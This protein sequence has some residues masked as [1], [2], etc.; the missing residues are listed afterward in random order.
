MLR[1]FRS[2]NRKDISRS[3]SLRPELLNGKVAVKLSFP[4]KDTLSE[5]TDYEIFLRC[6]NRYKSQTIKVGPLSEFDGTRTY[7]FDEFTTHHDPDI[8]LRLVN[9]Q[10]KRIVAD[11]EEHG[12]PGHDKGPGVKRSLIVV[13]EGEE[14]ES[15]LFKVEWKEVSPRPF[16]YLNTNSH[17]G[18]KTILLRDP[19]YAALMRPAVLRSVLTIILSKGLHTDESDSRHECAQKWVYLCKKK[20]WNPDPAPEMGSHAEITNWINA[21]VDS[22][23]KSIG[24]P[25][26]WSPVTAQV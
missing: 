6:T 13:N 18:I 26:Q 3:V 24:L 4:N 15:E 19:A 21:T 5:F 20:G 7:T 9:L 16:L 17:G 1:R 11:T 25:T 14:P 22:F 12:L 23:A 8:Q 2:A 10:N